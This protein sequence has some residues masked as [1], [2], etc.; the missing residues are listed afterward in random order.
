MLTRDNLFSAL[1]DK[2]P[3]AIDAMR[4]TAIQKYV[5][6]GHISLRKLRK[7]TV[8]RVGG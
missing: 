2:F 8:L 4:E 1:G 7:S 6:D 5:E 3:H